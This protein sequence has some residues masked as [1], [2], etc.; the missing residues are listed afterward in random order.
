MVSILCWGIGDNEVINWHSEE[1]AKLYAVVNVGNRLPVLPSADCLLGHAQYISQF[2]YGIT[3]GF[4]K[5]P[6][7]VPRSCHV[8]GW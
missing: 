6:D 2:G 7:T 5:V 3:T 4:T 1:L 8:D